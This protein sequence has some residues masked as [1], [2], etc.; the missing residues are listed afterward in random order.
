MLVPSTAGRD[1]GAAS[2]AGIASRLR[3]LKFQLSLLTEIKL[4]KQRNEYLK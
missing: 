4:A 3:P 1:A 2:I